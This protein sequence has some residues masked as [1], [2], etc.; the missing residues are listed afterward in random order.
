MTILP[1][2]VSV[3]LPVAAAVV[4]T[5][6]AQV[7]APG[8]PFAWDRDNPSAGLWVGTL[9]LGTV[10][11]F[12][13][14]SIEPG[15]G[16]WSV[17][18]TTI[19]LPA[20]MAMES[21]C[22][23]VRIEGDSVAF[24]LRAPAA[25]L[26][27]EGR[28][29]DEGQRLRG[30]AALSRDGAG[31]PLEGPFELART[32]RARDG[33]DPVSLSGAVQLPGFA[34]RLSI[35]VAGTPG[36]RT[37][38]EISIP[39]QGV[40]GHPLVNVSRDGDRFRATLPAQPDAVIEAEF[41]EGGARLSGVLKQGGISMPLELS[42]SGETSLAKP[43]RPQNPEPPYPYLVREFRVERDAG[44]ALAGTLTLPGSPGPHPAAV[45]I[46]GSG[47]QDRDET[48]FD[49]KP[50][51]VIADRLTLQGIAVARYDDRGVGESTGIETVAAA[52]STDLAA[53]A[54]SIV[55]HLRSQDGIDPAR[56]GLIGHSEGGIIAPMVAAGDGRI[57]FVVLLAGTAVTGGEI[58]VRPDRLLH[59]AQGAN[60]AGLDEIERSHRELLDLLAA[61]AAADDVRRAIRALAEAQVAAT[62][63]PPPPD[64]DALVEAQYLQATSPWLQSF[65]SYDP[66]PALRRLRCPVLALNGTLDLQ[67]H[68]EQ[69]LPLI[70]SA[71]RDVGGDVTVR[72][73]EGLN[74]LFQ[75]ATT[76]HP[77]EY[78]AIETTFDESVLREIAAWIRE[79]AGR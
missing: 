29:E 40:R 17:K 66:L 61:G 72:R 75:P 43:R 13:A 24:A 56:I 68:W 38:A 62:G 37:V 44:Y 42:R 1:R 76:G 26:R 49:H 19:I 31:P 36:G 5:G 46:S 70:E 64:L 59:Q 9:T 22:G 8:E 30:T 57:A 32:I 39:D 53:D 6:S 45:L 34:L 50:F 33:V 2:R 7:A 41:R 27:L 20:I 67:V 77:A 71:V 78:G 28:V 11:P 54:A 47:P 69:N 58:L 73:C 35:T 16:G 15:A 23:D 4:T 60:A 65:V 12:A 3:A 14:F 51:L 25:A 63:Q 10:S 79:K 18:A 21:P 52:T 55:E 74:H 48:I